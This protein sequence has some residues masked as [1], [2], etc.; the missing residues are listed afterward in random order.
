R[1][2]LTRCKTARMVAPGPPVPPPLPRFSA[3]SYP[4][5]RDFL[6]QFRPTA[7]FTPARIL[8]RL[9]QG[10]DTMNARIRPSV[11]ACGDEGGGP[12]FRP[13]G[14]RFS[15]PGHRPGGKARPKTGTP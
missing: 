12:V 3:S 11:P 7:P 14:A 1:A 2:R 9:T 15:S 4:G 13:E 8:L 5:Y 6:L 10:G